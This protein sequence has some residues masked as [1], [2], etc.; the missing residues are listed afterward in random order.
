[1]VDFSRYMA[2]TKQQ[3]ALKIKL[4]NPKLNMG[5]VMIEAGYSEKTAKAPTKLTKSKGWQELLA[6]I[7][8]EQLLK[9]LRKIALDD[10]D[11][12]ACLSAIDTLLKLKD[13]Y[14]A[15]KLNLKH[16]DSDYKEFLKQIK[17]IT[18]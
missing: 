1:L 5:K 7:D 3:N 4:K 17:A 11:K 8:D 2:T 13:R 6:Q 16:Q 10:K 15:G 12:R 18:R 9:K 14:P